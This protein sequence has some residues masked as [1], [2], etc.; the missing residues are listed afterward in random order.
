MVSGHV[1]EVCNDACVYCDDE[2]V[3]MVIIRPTR[4][5]GVWEA[6]GELEVVVCGQVSSSM[7]SSN[8]L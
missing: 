4:Q 1:L 2:C 6:A 8:A 7:S 3:H 5:H